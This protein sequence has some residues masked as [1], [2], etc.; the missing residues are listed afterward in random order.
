[1][2]LTGNYFPFKSLALHDKF[3]RFAILPLKNDFC[4]ILRVSTSSSFLYLFFLFNNS[5]AFGFH[6]LL[7]LSPLEKGH[8]GLEYQCSFVRLHLFLFAFLIIC[9]ESF[10][11]FDYF[12]RD[13]WFFIDWFVTLASR[14]LINVAVSSKEEVIAEINLSIFLR[15]FRESSLELSIL[16]HCSAKK[17]SK[18]NNC[19]F[20]FKSVTY[21]N[22]HQIH[23]FFYI[24][25]RF[26]LGYVQLNFP[27]VFE[28]TLLYEI[29]EDFFHLKCNFYMY[30]FSLELAALCFR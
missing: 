8:R 3:L 9:I 26:F 28:D 5:Y 24:H 10:C 2:G 7:R 16:E 6:L 22:W 29:S 17:K 13:V 4:R 14:F 27:A 18:L 1:M 20:F 30:C 23:L 25:M 21:S 12:Y 11:I 19:A 15:K